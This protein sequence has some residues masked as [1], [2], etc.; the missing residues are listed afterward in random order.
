VASRRLVA[1]ATLLLTGGAMLLAAPALA[2]TIYEWTLNGQKYAS[3][4]PPPP[5]AKLIRVQQDRPQQATRPT[6]PPANGATNAATA[7]LPAGDAAAARQVQQDLAKLQGDRCAETRERY[8]TYLQAQ[9]LFKPG[10]NNERQYLT[11]AELSAAR[12]NAKREMDAACKAP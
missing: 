2:G 3:D 7:A 8:N 10:P 4:R 11:D 1:A 9:R 6:P 5:G 12:V